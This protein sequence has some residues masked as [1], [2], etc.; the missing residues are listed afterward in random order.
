[1]HLTLKAIGLSILFFLSQTS[2]HSQVP[3]IL[4]G[5]PSSTS[6][7]LSILAKQNTSFY[8]EYGTEPGLY[9]QI[10]TNQDLIADTPLELDLKNLLP[11]TRYFYRIN[12][13]VIGTGN[14]IFSPEYSFHT[15]R[16][17]GSSFVFTVEADEHLY[18]KKGVENLY[19]ICLM[20]QA[21]DQPDFMLSLGDIFGDDH[22]WSTI[23]SGELDILHK[24][25]RPLLGS[26]CHSI[27]FYVCLGNHEGEN[28][29]YFNKNQGNNLCVWGTQWRKFYYPN[30]FPDG[31]YSGNTTEEPYGIGHPEN[32]Y[33]WTWGNTLF[34][35]LDVY[36]DQNDSNVKPGAWDWT[37]GFP[38]YTWLKNTLEGSSAMFKFVF[39]HHIR[40][41]GRG[42]ISNAKYFEWGG[43]E[44]NGSN[45]TFAAKRPG[46]AKPIHQ[47][48]KDNGVSIFFQGHDHVF[49]HEVLDG[50]TY[51]ALPMAADSTYHIGMLANSDA[52]TSDT[53]EGSGH[54]RVQVDPNCVKV[55]FVRAYLPADTVDGKHKNKEVA[56]SYTLGNCS[57]TGLQ[58]KNKKQ[59]QLNIYPNPAHDFIDI[60]YSGNIN[61][62]TIFRLLTSQG[63]VVEE[64]PL[65]RIETKQLADGIYTLQMW[66]GD[67][68]IHQKV[69]IKHTN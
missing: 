47:L 17:A 23:S 49:A 28:D 7:T 41:Q 55:D 9:S 24:N 45:F 39:A 2:V 67:V 52:Y 36:R 46:W 14:F 11:D 50:V 22:N 33:A 25:Y 5:R 44:Q 63:Q 29:Y 13:R 61:P 21:L 62:S 6:I 40:G 8:V 35:V 65:N 56:F 66:T 58:P 31:F 48:F 10:T 15:Q 16:K 30:P 69:L 1:M 57:T 20:N 27:P 54:L 53:V 19:Q 42:G 37:L 26:I 38:Q 68:F 3:N 18:D 60:S 32:Y 4:L 64:T 43:Y 51:Q 12:Y 34:V 59:T